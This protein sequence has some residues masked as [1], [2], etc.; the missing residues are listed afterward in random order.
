M[1]RK[2]LEGLHIFI[3][4]DTAELAFDLSEGLRLAG[5]SSIEIKASM[6]QAK[7]RLQQPPAP[8]VALLDFNL[9]GSETGLELAL[10]MREQPL[11]YHTLRISYSG[12]DSAALRAQLP[13]D[14]VYHAIVTKPVPLATLIEHIARVIEAN[15]VQDIAQADAS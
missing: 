14:R 8:D 7:K 12:S 3:V 2:P 13:D 6:R 9:V 11:L 4:E 5:A 10:W 15:R 1:L